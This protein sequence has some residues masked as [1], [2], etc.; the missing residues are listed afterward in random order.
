[1]C[2]WCLKPRVKDLVFPR[3]V[4]GDCV[5]ELIDHQ[6]NYVAAWLLEVL[7]G[8]AWLRRKGDREGVWSMHR[9]REFGW[10]MPRRS[11]STEVEVKEK[12]GMM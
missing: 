1:M 7:A 5:L 4:A 10:M 12:T 11:L 6:L 8:S 3:L 9:E 2:D